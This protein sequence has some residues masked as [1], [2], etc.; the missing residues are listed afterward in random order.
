MINTLETKAQRKL[1]EGSMNN[2]IEISEMYPELC[3]LFFSRSIL[4]YMLQ[5]IILYL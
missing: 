3:K 1:N 5:N 4:K 2:C